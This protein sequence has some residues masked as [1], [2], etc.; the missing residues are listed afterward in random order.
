VFTSATRI[1]CRTTPDRIDTKDVCRTVRNRTQRGTFWGQIA[2]HGVRPM[3]MQDDARLRKIGGRRPT[4][5]GLSPGR[6]AGL[7]GTRAATYAASVQSVLQVHGQCDG[8]RGLEPGGFPPYLQDAFELQTRVRSVSDLANQRDSEF[9]GGS[10]QADAARPA[11]GLDRRLDAATGRKAFVGEGARQTG[12]GDG[13]ER[14]AATR[15]GATFARTTRV[16]D[17]ARFAGTRVQRD[18]GGATGA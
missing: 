1:R 5:T 16:G 8:S 4:G 14:S 9:A 18:P 7:G 13:I 11:N 10:L 12:G 3:G 2:F 6:R 17:L 15:F